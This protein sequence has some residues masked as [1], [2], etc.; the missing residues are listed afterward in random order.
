MVNM[1]GYRSACSK[2]YY[3][4]E[5]R[6]MVFVVKG[7]RALW[8]FRE[9]VNPSGSPKRFSSLMAVINEEK[10][11]IGGWKVSKINEPMRM[12]YVFENK[13]LGIQIFT[14]NMNRFVGWLNGFK[15][16]GVARKNTTFWEVLKGKRECTPDGW[17]CRD[18]P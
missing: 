10:E 17:S 11:E 14:N 1:K 8:Q 15:N 2:H 9:G 16:N 7:L 4:F 12:K 6:D 3:K 18:N 13:E 5:S